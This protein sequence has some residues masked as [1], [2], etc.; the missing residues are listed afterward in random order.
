MSTETCDPGAKQKG[1][2]VKPKQLIVLIH[3]TKVTGNP[4]RADWKVEGLSGSELLAIAGPRGMGV[5]CT[6]GHMHGATR[7]GVTTYGKQPGVGNNLLAILVEGTDPAALTHIFRVL[8]ARAQFVESVEDWIAMHRAEMIT[9]LVTRGEWA[10][11]QLRAAA[12]DEEG[13]QAR[14]LLNARAGFHGHNCPSLEE[15]EVRPDDASDD[16]INMRPWCE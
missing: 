6:Q 7:Y 2:P 3:L 15:L 9:D 11:E 16:V 14:M 4:L 5:P 8:G 10:Y 13:G 1:N 12:V